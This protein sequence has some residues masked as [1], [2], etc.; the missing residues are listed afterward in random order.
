M[1]SCV[2]LVD[3][4]TNERMEYTLVYPDEANP[5]EGLLS[6]LSDLGLA[7]LGFCVGDTVTWAFPDGV[8]R[9]RINMIY[10]QP[11]ATHQYDK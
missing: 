7:I 11:E 1:N 9:L 10:F 2:Q 4:S 3:T 6:V 8:R 5:Q